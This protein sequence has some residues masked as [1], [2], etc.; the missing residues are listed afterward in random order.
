MTDIRTKRKDKKPR[1][2]V[3]PPLAT[4]TFAISHAVGDKIIRLL[5]ILYRDQLKYANI[6]KQKMSVR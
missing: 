5:R 2:M 1:F 4:L 3:N 6:I